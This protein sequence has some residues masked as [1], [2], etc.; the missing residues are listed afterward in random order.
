MRYFNVMS[1]VVDTLC[2]INFKCHKKKIVLNMQ[3]FSNCNSMLVV[4]KAPI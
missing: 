1:E 3:T 2:N 4:S